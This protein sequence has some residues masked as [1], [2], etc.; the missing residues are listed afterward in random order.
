MEDRTVFNTAAAALPP[1]VQAAN[2]E[3]ALRS[4]RSAA[5][6][7][8]S[9]DSE[10]L[11]PVDSAYVGD[12][13]AVLDLLELCER[14]PAKGGS[15]WM[16]KN[17]VRR[18][19][20]QEMCSRAAIERALQANQPRPDDVLQRMFEAYVAETAPPVEKQSPAELVASLQV[21][22]WL[23]GTLEGLPDRGELTNRLE[24][25]Q[26][27]Q[28]FRELVGDNFRGRTKELV[29]LG[30]YVAN[31]QVHR[32]IYEARPLMIFG[33]GGVGK[34]TLL[35]RFILE[36][37]DRQQPG[38][39]A[40]CYWDFDR[41]T[42]LPEEPM[43]LL[44]ELVQQ[45]ALQFAQIRP[46]AQKLRRRLLDRLAKSAG[47]RRVI[48]TRDDVRGELEYRDVAERYIRQSRSQSEYRRELE[49]LISVMPRS[50]RTRFLLVLDTF[51][52]VQEVSLEFTAALWEF[53]NELQSMFPFMRVVVA[54]RVELQ[55][56]IPHEPYELKEL[57]EEATK[58]YLGARGVTDPRL[59][60]AI[61]RKVGGDPLS[62]RLVVDGLRQGHEDLSQLSALPADFDGLSIDHEMNQG[63]L[64]RR[65]LSR[66]PA[67]QVRRLAHPGLVLRQVTPALI[68][69]VLAE[70]CGVDVPSDEIAESLFEQ[71][72][73]QV[74]LVARQG[75]T[76]RHRPD[77][78]KRMLRALVQTE[79]GAVYE[80][81]R[82][83]VDFYS[84]QSA[85]PQI[86]AE[87][88]YH[89]LFIARGR[90]EIDPR[91]VPG[92]AKYL[93]D[94]VDEIPRE[95]RGYL[96]SKLE[97][98]SAEFDWDEGDA[99]SKEDYTATRAQDAIAVNDLVG[100]VQVLA[101]VCDRLPGS[102]LF[103]L[104]AQALEGLCR[105]PEAIAAANEG[106]F[107]ARKAGDVELELDL[108]LVAIRAHEK[109]GHF[110]RA[111]GSLER[112]AQLEVTL[113]APYAELLA[114]E[115]QMHRL[116]IC[117]LDPANCHHDHAALCQEAFAALDPLFETAA[118]LNAILLVDLVE[119]IGV[120]YPEAV[121]R[122]VGLYL[123][124]FDEEAGQRQIGEL[125]REYGQ[126][127]GRAHRVVSDALAPI[128]RLLAAGQR[129][130]AMR[131]AGLAPSAN[132]ESFF[133][134][135]F[136]GYTPTQR[137]VSALTGLVHDA[138]MGAGR[139]Q[140]AM[141]TVVEQVAT[142]LFSAFERRDGL[143]DFLQREFPAIVGE[144]A[145]E[146]TYRE[147]LTNIASV[148][149]RQGQ[150][151]H[152]IER[153]LAHQPDNSLLK[154]L[155]QQIAAAAPTVETAEP[156]RYDIH[157]GQVAEG[158]RI[159]IGDSYA[160][161]PTFSRLPREQLDALPKSM[162]IPS[163]DRKH[164]DTALPEL[165]FNWALGM[166]QAMQAVC[167]VELAG[168]T[169]MPQMK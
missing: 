152:L 122:L 123:S 70:P 126:V 86:R 77:V 54:G 147:T 132:W 103:R 23:E 127:T 164:G 11:R 57:D 84:Q 38:E 97:I 87:E 128:A 142:A 140:T 109:L 33:P 14:T 60:D 114:L 107:S 134:W 167:Q 138:L 40:F 34:S 1:P 67:P 161:S 160:R 42:L 82:R 8:S 88:I 116:R 112:A 25:Q 69:Q 4:Y 36:T 151:E 163:I 130:Q 71:L 72:A 121:I 165:V 52:R 59:A 104:E 3:A 135:F 120:E 56:D 28:P 168:G 41:T 5:A 124:A 89:R 51:E 90:D 166:R 94:A 162:P 21:L 75:A 64:Y 155:R 24:W 105:Y 157:I 101:T 110:D 99:R 10:S 35:A 156:G 150:T 146:A 115:L 49:H 95:M 12:S 154:A 50:K 44:A 92:V 13:D 17:S 96:I 78:R 144:V 80:I 129:E 159:F 18:Q 91:W 20:L 62:L 108:L 119:E 93:R 145:P 85:D 65:Y 68:R 63:W 148:L 139:S 149:E 106:L 83:A 117:R 113:K 43:T 169:V 7:L 111:G 100:A 141:S 133:E 39:F 76:L 131:T 19:A 9:F 27:L 15:R 143:M 137:L 31:S 58:G 79:G 81:H 6:V 118:R 55:K 2:A 37:V 74:S 98:T 26:L 48:V 53:L 61:Y 45:L 125:L 47:A 102:G 16:L 29:D 66:I 46:Q 136:K 32:T 73:Q 22:D 158:A 153:A 30:R